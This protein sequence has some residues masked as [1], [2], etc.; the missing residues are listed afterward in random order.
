VTLNRGDI[1]YVVTEYGIA[2]LTGKNIRERAMDLISI[3]HPKF[4]QELIEQAKK[5]NLIYRD[6]AFIPGKRGEYPEHLETLRTT[7]SGLLI[8]LR[9]VKIND[10][11]NIKDFFYSLSDQSFQ[12]RFM[13]SRRDMPH[14]LRQEYV[15]IDYSKEMVILAC[16]EDQGKEI[17]VGMG[18]TIK[19]ENQMA[20]VAFAVR[21]DYHNKGVGSELLSYLTILAKRE[22]L[23]GFTAEVLVEN[24]PML[25]VFE[26]LMT[27]MHKKINYGA[28]ELIMRF[29]VSHEK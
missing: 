15:V 21:D 25:H 20:E 18:Q 28:Y 14:K 23:Q 13:S 3:A 26:K 10:E 16:V 9:P 1:M 19:D 24:K 2:Y 12:R 4:R 7:R 22:G 5:L 8:R 11:T 6:Q 27:D 29:G 17:V